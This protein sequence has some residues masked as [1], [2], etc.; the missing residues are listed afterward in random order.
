MA[1]SVGGLHILMKT[2]RT[3][4][5]VQFALTTVMLFLVVDLFVTRKRRTHSCFDLSALTDEIGKI[6]INLNVSLMRW[7][8]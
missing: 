4:A 5:L 3:R 7:T 1:M 2:A 8:I 6:G